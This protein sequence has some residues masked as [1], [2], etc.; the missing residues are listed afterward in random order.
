MNTQTKNNNLKKDINKQIQE[1]LSFEEVK[2]YYKEFMFTNNIDYNIV[3]YGNLLI[4]YDDIREFYKEHGF[5]YP[6]KDDDFIWNLY[7]KDVGVE[8][9]KIIRNGG[10]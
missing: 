2:H 3:Q 10:F 9:R 7:K 8:V 5:D 6:K 4:Y 1:S